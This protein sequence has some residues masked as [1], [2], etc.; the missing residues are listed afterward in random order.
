MNLSSPRA[1]SAYVIQRIVISKHGKLATGK[2]IL[3]LYHTQP[4]SVLATLTWL[5]YN[6]V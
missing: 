4:T 1:G 5:S 6:F 3:K 2:I